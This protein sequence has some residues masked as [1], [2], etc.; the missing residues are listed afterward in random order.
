MS[1]A[2]NTRVHG[3]RGNPGGGEALLH[4]VGLGLGPGEDQHLTP[5]LVVEQA[6]QQLVLLVG[7]N[8]VDLL[9]DPL[10]RG[11]GRR[12]LEPDRIVHDPE[13]ESMHAL[14]HG[15]RE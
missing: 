11:T 15:G 8:R 7:A 12:G 1:V 3:F 9:L 4:G 6:L 14:G 2:T 5:T 13:R 10:R